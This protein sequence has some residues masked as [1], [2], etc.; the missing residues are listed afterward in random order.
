[1][2]SYRAGMSKL[3]N[4]SRSGLDN[5]MRTFPSDHMLLKG[6]ADFIQMHHWEGL[7][8][9]TT[10]DEYG[11]DSSREF[12]EAV[13]ELS[14]KLGAAGLQTIRDVQVHFVE[15]DNKDD[16]R[17]TLQTIKESSWRIVVL[18]A[19]EE[20]AP[21]IMHQ[22][23]ALRMVRMGWCWIGTEWVTDSMFS[24]PV[25][26]SR[27][28]DGLSRDGTAEY[29]RDELWGLIAIQHDTHQTPIAARLRSMWEAEKHDFIN[30]TACPEATDR[31][32]LS[33]T[34]DFAFDA[35]MVIG[36]GTAMLADQRAEQVPP[37]R[38]HWWRTAITRGYE[39]R[40]PLMN[41]MV[42]NELAEL[43]SGP[44]IFNDAGDPIAVRFSVVNYN[45]PAKGMKEV[46]KW[47]QTQQD[48]VACGTETLC[49][50]LEVSDSQISWM[51]RSENVPTD[52][53]I[54]HDL[55]HAIYMTLVIALLI[56]SIIGGNIIE[57]LHFNYLPEA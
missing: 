20:I 19:P 55:I 1:M 46:G 24:H 27:A 16:I 13:E 10:N 32:T 39:V 34:A 11:V 48:Y 6:V 56:V 12:L 5:F 8:F 40:G 44:V 23:V 42:E 14:S 51:G 35:V 49:G 4:F 50:V 54:E 33:E 30:H 37:G 52:R 2:I 31:M 17:E 36:A 38:G 29:M 18:H 26:E 7:S 22:A 45:Y 21:R 47:I 57:L 25:L 15:P 3:T 9:I 28:P 43:A 53:V 41:A